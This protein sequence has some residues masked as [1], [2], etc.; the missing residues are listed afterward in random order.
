VADQGAKPIDRPQRALN[1][2]IWHVLFIRCAYSCITRVNL[3]LRWS[4]IFHNIKGTLDTD[5]HIGVGPRDSN[6]DPILDSPRGI[7]L[8]GDGDVYSPMGM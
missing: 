1:S 8:L 4:S 3:T 2:Q 7:P 6:G 5:L